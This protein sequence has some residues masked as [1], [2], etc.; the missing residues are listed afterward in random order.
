[1]SD[2]ERKQLMAEV[3]ERKRKILREVEVSL[4]ALSMFYINHTHIIHSG[5][6]YGAL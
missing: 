2:K 1:M 5:K 4:S 6:G 3:D